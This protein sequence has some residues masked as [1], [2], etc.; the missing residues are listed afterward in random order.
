MSKTFTEE[1][2]VAGKQVWET[3]QKLAEDVSVHRIKVI[4]PEGKVIMDAPAALGVAG[5]FVLQPWILIAAGMALFS[6]YRI[7][8]VRKVAEEGEGEEEVE[9]LDPEEIIISAETPKP[10]GQCHGITRSGERCKRKCADDDLYCAT[11]EPV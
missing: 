7:E 2:E 11:H 8:V 9:A 5:I 3:I 10:D 6:S 4:N 1:I